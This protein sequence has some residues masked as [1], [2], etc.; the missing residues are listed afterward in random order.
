MKHANEDFG[1]EVIPLLHLVEVIGH[2]ELGG[3]LFLHLL[4]A[5]ARCNFSESKT[6]ILTVNLEDSL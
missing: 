3:G 6:S 5:N 4:D 1:Y 2:L